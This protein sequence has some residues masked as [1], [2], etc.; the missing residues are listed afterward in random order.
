M[1][2]KAANK[3]KGAGT[4]RRVRPGRW[5]QVNNLTK[6]REWGKNSWESEYY[7]SN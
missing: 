1:L 4:G 7:V 5:A 6:Q 2:Q 3:S